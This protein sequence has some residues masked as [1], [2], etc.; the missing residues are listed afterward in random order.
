MSG[1]NTEKCSTLKHLNPPHLLMLQDFRE[2]VGA[3]VGDEGEP[4][5]NE[6][7]LREILNEL[8]DIYT[9]HRRILNE[10]EN[11]IRH[12]W[13]TAQRAAQLTVGL[14]THLLYRFS[15][16]CAL[17]FMPSSRDEQQRIA[18]IFLSRKAEFL[19]FTTYIG[20]YDRS[21]SLLEDSCRSSSAFAA[22][23]QQFE[24]GV[25]VLILL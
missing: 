23:V 6:D 16:P 5:L 19:V 15:L 3:A 7:R 8:P 14:K 9:L 17:T 25:T 1:K 24:V 10:L 13:A 18:D 11:R 21:V 12:W 20:H 4:V 2:A 22:V